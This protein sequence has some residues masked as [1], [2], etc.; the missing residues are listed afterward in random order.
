MPVLACIHSLFPLLL[1]WI[2]ACE[3]RVSCLYISLVDGCLGLDYFQFW[4]IVNK[5]IMNIHVPVF[6]PT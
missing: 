2:P 1:N 6:L 4:I 3:C 5:A